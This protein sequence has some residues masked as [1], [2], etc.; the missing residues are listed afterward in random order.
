MAL[1]RNGRSL[2]TMIAA[3][4]MLGCA[5]LLAWGQADRPID[6]W[7]EKLEGIWCDAERGCTHWW[8]I[9]EVRVRN[10]GK[11]I[12]ILTGGDPRLAFFIGEIQESA[13][14]WMIKGHKLNKDGEKGEAFDA[15]VSE[16]RGLK[17]VIEGKIKGSL[18][19]KIQDIEIVDGIRVQET[20]GG[21]KEKFQEVGGGIRISDAKVDDPTLEITGSKIVKPK[22]S[23]LT[24]NEAK[25]KEPQMEGPTIKGAKEIKAD[26]LIADKMT[27]KEINEAKLA[28]SKIV[29][30]KIE[31]GGRQVEISVP[32]QISEATIEGSTKTL[33]KPGDSGDD[34]DDG[35]KKRLELKGTI[36][37]KFTLPN[38]GTS[39]WKGDFQGEFTAL[40]QAAIEGI[41]VAIPMSCSQAGRA[42][43]EVEKLDF[44]KRRKATPTV[45]GPG[46]YRSRT[47]I[48]EQEV[49]LDMLKAPGA[50]RKK[51]QEAYA[52]ETRSP[53]PAEP[54]TTGKFM[55]KVNGTVSAIKPHTITLELPPLPVLDHKCSVKD[56]IPKRTLKLVKQHDAVR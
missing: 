33:A 8:T 26:E 43:S 14:R 34:D 52:E 12:A 24:I 40:V 5:P 42:L 9:Y 22:I 51:P 27:A 16:L 18:R 29:G 21:D 28:A 44:E 2:P 35:K 7:K 20:K 17:E 30:K 48:G 55:R 56:E 13:G 11:G 15:V 4:L 39:D 38:G 3:A 1:N 45:L 36:K 19:A 53:R 25:I 37:G 10:D 23:N 46:S 47:E 32:I 31:G 41:Y 54:H 6:S 50:L 49:R